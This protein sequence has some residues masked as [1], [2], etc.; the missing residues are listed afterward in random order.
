MLLKKETAVK[1]QESALVSALITSL[2][3]KQISD[4]DHNEL[5]SFVHQDVQVTI[6][7]NPVHIPHAGIYKGKREWGR[8]LVDFKSNVYIEEII[9]QAVLKEGDNTDIHLRLSGRFKESES[10]FDL[11]W[12]YALVTEGDEI[13]KITVFYDTYVFQKGYKSDDVIHVE[14]IKNSPGPVY[15]PGDS[16]D[17]RPLINKG[18]QAFYFDQDIPALM[19]VMDENIQFVFKGDEENTPYAGLYLGLKGLEQF[20][21]DIVPNFTPTVLNILHSVQQGNRINFRVYEEGLSKPT[22]KTYK[23]T[24]LQ[25]FLVYNNKIVEFKTYN[26]SYAVGQSY[27]RD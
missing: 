15:F 13:I 27:V 23:I 19:S 9:C 11:E 17:Y 1:E 20:L 7:G 8:Y 22:G 12:V 16:T 25:S 14:D 10:S 5:T 6:T 18:Y 24:V 3:H 21:L 26:D 2:L 4:S